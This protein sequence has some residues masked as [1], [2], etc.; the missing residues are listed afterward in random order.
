MPQGYY[1]TDGPAGSTIALL[2][3]VNASYSVGIVGLGVGALAAVLGIAVLVGGVLGGALAFI[4]FNGLS[5]STLAGSSFSQ[6]VFDF[7]VTPDLFAQGLTLALVIGLVGGFLPALRAAR[8]M[9]AEISPA[10]N[11]TRTPLPSA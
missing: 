6:V 1:H 5:V 4:V 10:P 9:V 3:A 2:A 7:A 11:E 8:E